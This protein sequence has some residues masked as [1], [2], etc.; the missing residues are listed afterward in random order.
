MSEHNEQSKVIQWAAY[1]EG[2]YPQLRLL[3]A[4]ANGGLRNKR[5]GYM[6]KLE[7]VKPGVPDLFLSSPKWNYLDHDYDAHGLYIEMK[8]GKNK[9]TAS[10]KIWMDWLEEE[11]YAVAVCWTFEQARDVLLDYLDESS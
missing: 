5:T 1:N 2:K 9:P 8:F 3:F 7:G 6:L 11:N 10:Q 4:I